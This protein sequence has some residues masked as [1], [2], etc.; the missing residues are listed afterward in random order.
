MGV[1][2]ELFV[3][4]MVRGRGLLARAILRAQLASPG[5][6]HIYAAL[7]AVVNSKLPEVGDLLVRRL[8]LQFRRAYRRNDKIVCKACVKFLAH[9]VNQRIVH[10]LLALQLCLLLLEKLTDD[11]VEICVEFL[12]VLLRNMHKCLCIV[13]HAHFECISMKLGSGVQ[14]DV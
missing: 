6:T 13:T 3:E 11:S 12:Q 9:L 7:L 2:Q 8:F 1:Y 14:L 4:N 10:E 5:F